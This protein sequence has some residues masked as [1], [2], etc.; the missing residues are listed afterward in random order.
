MDV[1]NRVWERCEELGR[2]W[3]AVSVLVSKGRFSFGLAEGITWRDACLMVYTDS[4]VSS[5]AENL[6]SQWSR[7][8]QCGVGGDIVSRLADGREA[9]RSWFLKNPLGEGT[10]PIR[11]VRYEMPADLD[12]AY[13]K[14]GMGR[15][16]LPEETIQGLRY[17]VPVAMIDTRRNPNPTPEQVEEALQKDARKKGLE[18]T[19][20][21]SVPLEKLPEM[22]RKVRQREAAAVPLD[23]L[24][25]IVRRGVQK[26]E[27]LGTVPTLE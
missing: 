16:P 11:K 18:G 17:H 26:K 14:A 12:K 22:L 2:P 8:R 23:Q 10:G 19:K 13:R 24:P 21:P 1:V 15:P 25:E 4:L 6:T 20:N 9:P 27:R 5:H 3:D 7:D